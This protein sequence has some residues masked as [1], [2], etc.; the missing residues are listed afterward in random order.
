VPQHRDL[1][2]VT[3]YLPPDIIE[4]LEKQAKDAYLPVSAVARNWLISAVR[5]QQGQKAPRR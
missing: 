5:G 2:P 1:Q 3:V 4:Y